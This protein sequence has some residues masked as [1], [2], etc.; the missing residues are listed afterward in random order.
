MARPIRSWIGLPQPESRKHGPG[1]S[2]GDDLRDPL[3]LGIQ[4]VGVTAAFGGLGW[5][6]DRLLHTF[7]VLMAVGA[8]VGLFGIIYLTYKRLR[9]TDTDS[10]AA[11]G[12]RGADK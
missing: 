12:K 10:D 8:V 6:L 5:W 11:S 1:A 7:P 2:G 4:I 3:Q 9:A